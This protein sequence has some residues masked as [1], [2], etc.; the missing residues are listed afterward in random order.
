MLNNVKKI[1]LKEIN[2]KEGNILKYID[3]NNRYFK[4][5]GEIY[6]SEIKKG[7]YK[8]WNLHKRCQCLIFVPIGEVEF[9][10]RSYNF[11]KD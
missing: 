8:G 9:S 6:F 10:F 11:K 5:F 4:K 1:K 7:Y 3:K 2:I